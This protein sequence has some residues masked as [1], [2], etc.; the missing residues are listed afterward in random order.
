MGERVMFTDVYC[1]ILWLLWIAAMAY[2]YWGIR[3]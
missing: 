2:L 1:I 3:W